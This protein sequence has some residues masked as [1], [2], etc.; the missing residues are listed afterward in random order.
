MV[1]VTP[2]HTPR[3]LWV[4]VAIRWPA[5]SNP[6]VQ[7]RA[8]LSLLVWRERLP[9]EL[10]STVIL[11]GS[12]DH[13]GNFRVSVI[14][15][16]QTITPTGPVSRNIAAN[17][18]AQTH[19]SHRKREGGRLFRHGIALIT[20]HTHTTHPTDTTHHHTPPRTHH[21]NTP[22]QHTTH[23]TQHNTH[24]HTH[25]HTHHTHSLSCVSC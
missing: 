13:M 6:V 11:Q 5:L 23:H 22:P 10:A 1:V 7:I 4:G 15:Y 3:V 24:T 2:A 18:A 25:T 8:H 9:P 16:A 17:C 19:T 14:D 20:V 12:H 21:H